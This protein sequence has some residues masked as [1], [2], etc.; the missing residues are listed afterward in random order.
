MDKLLLARNEIDAIDKQFA[1]LYEQRMKAVAKVAEYK[2]ENGLPI[3][4][5]GREKLV[6]ERNTAY[7]SDDN[8]KPGYVKVLAKLMEVSKDYQRQSIYGSCIGYQ[9]ILGAFSHIAAKRLF[10][11][12]N[13]LSYSS[14]RNVI[15]AIEEDAIAAG[16]LPF[17]NSSA[18]EVG[19]VMNLLFKHPDLY[20]EAYYDLK[21]EQN[22]L[23]IKGAKREDITKVYSHQQALDQSSNYLRHR[24]YELISYPNTALAASFVAEK[25]DF[26]KAAIASK[27]TAEIY[28]LSILEE[29]IQNFDSNYTRFVI[30]SKKP[31]NTGEKTGIFFTVKNEAGCLSEIINI[32]SESGF[33]MSSLISHAMPELPWEYYFFAQLDCSSDTS[34]YLEMA[35]KLAKHCES[36]RCIGSYSK[37]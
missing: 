10:P 16:I 21:V 34:S 11:D 17:E 37:I 3:F 23:G 30:V 18:G 31:H 14:F 5:E 19:D 24:G 8:L 33:N 15:E 12:S 1:K 7:L 26:D 9:G 27:D 28:G 25:G 6:I 4:D 2:K 29:N 20:I 22:L 35:Q 13:L 32:I 36:Y